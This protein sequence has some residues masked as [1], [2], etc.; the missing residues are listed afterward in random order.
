MTVNEAVR[1]NGKNASLMNYLT[2]PCDE[3]CSLS[4]RTAIHLCRES[5]RLT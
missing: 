2:V 3:I 4:W 1:V 5:V